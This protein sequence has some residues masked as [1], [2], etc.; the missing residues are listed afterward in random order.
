MKLDAL[1][2]QQRWQEGATGWDIGAASPFLMHVASQFPLNTRILIPGCGS[3]YEAEALWRLGYSGVEVVD[4]ATEPLRKLAER[5]P[6]FPLAQM[7]HGDLFA[8]EGSFEVI[9]E[10][11]FFCALDPQWR[12]RYA[13]KMA[14][15]LVPKGTLAG[16][17]FDFPLTQEGPPF[18]GSRE[19]YQELFSEYFTLLEMQHTE[20][21]IPP[22]CGRELGFRLEKKS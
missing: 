12:R 11:T 9:L 21:S 16:L 6:D 18:G 8:L 5:V 7:H 4:I 2:W 20:L 22:R 3:G 19:E 13:E 1:Y 15:L 17:L 10:Q 14:S